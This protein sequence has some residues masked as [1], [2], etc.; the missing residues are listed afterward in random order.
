MIQTRDLQIIRPALNRRATIGA[1]VCFELIKYP[2]LAFRWFK[3]SCMDWAK[4]FSFHHSAFF[5]K[6]LTKSERKVLKKKKELKPKMPQAWGQR[7]NKHKAGSKKVICLGC[8]KEKMGKHERVKE[9]FVTDCQS[10]ACL[11][12]LTKA[13]WEISFKLGET[14]RREKPFRAHHNLA[15]LAEPTL[16][17]LLAG[18]H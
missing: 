15:C 6:V 18:R 1:H 3:L 10:I 12:G 8:R 2:S 17:G 9:A 13:S 5:L 14:D 16:K 7:S 11:V 4:V